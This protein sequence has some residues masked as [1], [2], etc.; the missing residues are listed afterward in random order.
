MKESF[1]RAS[2]SKNLTDAASCAPSFVSLESHVGRLTDPS[3]HAMAARFI[4]LRDAPR[5]LGMD[6]NRFNPAI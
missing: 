3:A 5:Y 2:L 1:G 4:R 6:K